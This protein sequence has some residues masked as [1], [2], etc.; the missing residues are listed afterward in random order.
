[1]SKR[2]YN[3]IAEGL[4]E[5]IAIVRGDSTCGGRLAARS[6]RGSK[7]CFVATKH[8]QRPV[9]L[10]SNQQAITTWPHSIGIKLGRL[11]R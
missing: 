4:M 10:H 11:G 2:A 6:M 7:R 5:A 9:P 8:T 1:M 3:K